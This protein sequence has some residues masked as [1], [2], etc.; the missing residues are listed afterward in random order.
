MLEA[1]KHIDEQVLLFING[2][3]NPFLDFTMYWLSDTW[4]WLPLYAFLIFIILKKW[5]LK[6]GLI[7][8][9]IAFALLG[10]SE[11]IS[12]FIFKPWIARPRPCYVPE[13]M[14]QFHFI[15]DGCGGAYGFF[16]SH[17]SDTFAITIFLF[18][19]FNKD[20][21]V[22]ALIVWAVLV[23]VSRVYLGKHYPLDV[24]AG[25]TCG[26]LLGWFGYWVLLKVKVVS[27]KL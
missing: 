18:L 4:I 26:A 2:L 21:R 24:L 16:S 20:K 13:L 5:K 23:S 6:E 7:I 14:Q 12:S 1:L 9:A 11:L 3:H 25:M 19:L 10:L 17:A 8:I 27:N 15:L 22:Y